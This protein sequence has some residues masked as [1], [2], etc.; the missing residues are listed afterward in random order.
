MKKLI[1][2]AL[3]LICNFSFG[4]SWYFSNSGNDATGNGTITTPY[5]TIAKLNTLTL[6]A[7]DVILFNRGNTFYGGVIVPRGNLS[8]DAYGTG[9]N[10]IFTGL[11]TVTGWVSL[12]SNLYEAPVTN[13][14]TGVNLVLRNGLVQQVGRYPNVGTTNGGWLVISSGN[15]TSLTGPALSSTTNWTGAE[16]V[17]KVVRWDIQHR[18]VT[19]HSAGTLGFSAFSN[20]YSASAGFGYFFQRDSRT[21]DV[22]GEWWYDNTN[23]KLRVYSTSVPTSYTY[24]ISTVDTLFKNVYGSITLKNI[25]FEGANT[26]AVYNS[27]GANFT[28][29][30]C[31]VNYS[32]KCAIKSNSATA[33]TINNCT[34]N[35]SLGS[36]IR[37]SVPFAG[38]KY[39][40]CNSNNVDSTAWIAGMEA[41]DGFDG[42]S[43]LTVNGGDSVICMYN[44][45]TNSGYNGIEWKGSQAH[46][47]Y[48]Y[49]NKYCTVRNDGSGIYTVE[50]G[51]NS[52]IIPRNTREVISN[53][54]TNGVGNY[55]GSPD[56][57][58]TSCNGMYFDLGTRNVLIDGN[59]CAYNPSGA[60]HGNNNDSLTFRNNTFFQ[61]NSTYSFQRFSGA[62]PMRSIFMN[63]NILDGYRFVYRNLSLDVPS[64]TTKNADILAMGIFTNNYYSLRSGIDSS[65]YA[66]TTYASGSN[67]VE[68]AN[69][70]AYLTG[71]VGIE[72]SATVFA[73]TGTL[74]TN[75][76]S[77]L[78]IVNFSGLN[79]KDVYNTNY[80][81]YA[82]I[83]AWSS[84][85]LI[86]NGTS[87]IPPVA[88]AGIDQS[89]T[90]PINSVTLTGTGT[91][92]DGTI[93]SYS[94]FKLS[95]NTGDVISSPSSASTAVSFTTA[96]TY[97]YV[98][99]VTDNLGLTGKDT[100]QVTVIAARLIAP[101]VN[102]GIDQTLQ[103]PTFA[104]LLATVTGSIST[105]T[106][107]FITVPS[108]STAVFGTPATLATTV[109]SLSVGVYSIKC[110]VLDF[111]GLTARDTMQITVIAPPANIPPTVDAIASTTIQLPISS[112]SATAVGRDVD[113][114]IVSYAWT[115]I[116]GPN[117]ATIS[118]PST[119]GTNFTG[120]IQGIYSFKV[121]VTDNSGATGSQTFQVTV[122]AAIPPVNQPPVVSANASITS[123]TLSANSTS[124][125]ATATDAD[126]TIASTLW[127]VISGPATYT[128]GTPTSLT[129]TFNGLV[130][131]VYQ[132]KFK[133]TDNIGDTAVAYLQITVLAAPVVTAPSC[134]AGTSNS[135]TLPISSTVLTG[136]VTAGTYSIASYLWTQTGGVATTITNGTTTAATITGITVS[137]TYQ[138]L[139]KATDINGNICSTTFK[140]VVFD[141]SCNCII[142]S[143]RNKKIVN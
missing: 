26:D 65:L 116:T 98:L 58:N 124:L 48:N 123:M 101:T 117:T 63:N 37:I 50:N 11:S 80:S 62:L 44:T 110:T 20:G 125:V 94:W 41:S 71:T 40:V 22:D 120:L 81:N 126:G 8:Y 82:V 141:P 60:F 42:G 100:V 25:D 75:P 35:L 138:Y 78:I 66:V 13:V 28:V 23:S 74:Y 30:N 85:I 68:T 5:A 3:L 24:R 93:A 47:K 4:R 12:G 88:N 99:T 96:G 112:T 90:L 135:Y 122:L 143:R 32:G 59:T 73:N 104:S 16:V 51:N 72:T 83:P 18:I 140:I 118:S 34:T 56:T 109:T 127:S 36:G 1:T 107:S 46:I 69:N 31:N 77:T 21:L 38:L 29:T 105:V 84:K 52:L 121:T 79:K 14:K 130:A 39:V 43:G 45:V 27:G 86:P 129:S 92:A 87:N 33:T 57:Y 115:E 134:T 95:G 10:P 136:V 7:G 91:D 111:N 139:F 89:I 76:T 70:F 137:G 131:G 114:T 6:A 53:I 113:G 97:Q 106:W 108:G 17:I 9:A 119:S 19:S 54:C 49:A 2:I 55:L 67:Y 142:N 103:L 64:L 61:N 132:L 133:A 15:S 128:I 102:A